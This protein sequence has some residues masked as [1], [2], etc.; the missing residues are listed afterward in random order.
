[1]EKT[2]IIDGKSVKFKATGGL[3]YRY[4]AQFG[5][6]YFADAL[7][8]ASAGDMVKS[9]AKNASAEEWKNYRLRCAYEMTSK[10]LSAMYDILWCLAKT[11]DASIPD[12]QT[13]LDGFEAFPVFD[14]WEQLEDI[15][16]SNVAIDPK[17]V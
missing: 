17:N 6:E 14:I 4:K 16:D 5:R 13:W 3:S 2:I 15:M 9:P 10:A 12:P 8:I 7:L 11:A 1:M